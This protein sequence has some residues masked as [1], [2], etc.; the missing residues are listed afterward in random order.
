M[1]FFQAVV[2]W[3]RNT[4][5][6][7][8]EAISD[9]VANSRLAI[10]DSKKQVVEFT[11]K[12]ADLMAQTKN[13][14]RQL[15]DAQADVTKYGG[16]AEKAAA[17]GSEDDVRKAVQ[18]KQASEARAKTLQDEI[19]NNDQLTQSLRTD[20]DKARTRIAEAESNLSQLAARRDGARVREALT[21]AST[22]FSSGTS[23]LSALDDLKKQVET[24]EDRASAKAELSKDAATTAGESL[25]EKYSG[26]T[27]NVDDEVQRLMAAAKNKPEQGTP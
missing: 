9:P 10:E 27:A 8:A 17:A 26:A 23:P 15:L 20:L 5:R 21:E 3:M 18:L 4:D 11:S 14:Q 25:E 2:N 13:L 19:T 1:K 6:Q 22:Q 24:E 12:I 16:Y 7:A